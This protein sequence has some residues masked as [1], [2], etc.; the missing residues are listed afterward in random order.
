M[1]CWG[2]SPTRRVFFPQKHGSESLCPERESSLDFRRWASEGSCKDWGVEIWRSGETREE[3]GACGGRWLVGNSWR[4]DASRMWRMRITS[5]WSFGQSSSLCSVKP[6]GW[7]RSLKV[8]RTGVEKGR[9]KRVSHIWVAVGQRRGARAAVVGEMEWGQVGGELAAGSD[10]ENANPW[11]F[12]R[13]LWE[14]LDYSEYSEWVLGPKGEGNLVCFGA[15]LSW[16]ILHYTWPGNRL[17]ATEH[18]K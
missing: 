13:V 9:E 11:E 2:L 5:K 8:C 18:P 1:S 12:T 16:V 10:Y 17:G 14:A 7:Y 3:V 4:W 6:H 15:L